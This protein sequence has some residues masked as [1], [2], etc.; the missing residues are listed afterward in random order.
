MSSIPQPSSNFET[1]IKVAGLMVSPAVELGQP[2]IAISYQDDPEEL[3]VFTTGAAC[4][5]A[6]ALQAVAV[7]VMEQSEA[8]AA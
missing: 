8:R 7:H 1:R 2:A 3:F 6:A 5:L 4:A